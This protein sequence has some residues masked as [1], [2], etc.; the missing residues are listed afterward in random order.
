MAEG[1]S[2]EQYDY[3]PGRM[4][5]T[6][7][8]KWIINRHINECRMM[9]TYSKDQSLMKRA[10][11]ILQILLKPKEDKKFNEELDK[12]GKAEL[13]TIEEVSPGELKLK[14]YEIEFEFMMKR[15]EACIKLGTRRG[16][17]I[18]KE[19]IDEI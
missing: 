7:D 5:D 15:F 14:K 13:K 18:V 16:L 17:I 1:K 2:Y 19:A 9:L 11:K 4:P 10:V 8:Y 3:E 6:I 12:L